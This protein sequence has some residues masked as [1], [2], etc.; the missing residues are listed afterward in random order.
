MHMARQ[1]ILNICIFT[2]LGLAIVL[3]SA[4]PVLAKSMSS[5][6]WTFSTGI[7][8][9]APSVKGE[10]AYGGDIDVDINEIVDNL[11]IAF[12]GLLTARK[13]KFSLLVDVIYM[14]LEDTSNY[15]LTSGPLGLVRLSITNME[16]QAWVVT[17]AAAYTVVDT[18][19]LQLDLLA[20]ARYL[21]IDTDVE[22][23]EQGPLETR[24]FS[25]SGSN[26]VWDGIVGAR[27]SVKINEKWHLPFHFDVGTG[28]TDMTWQ[29]FGG[30]A[31]KFSNVDLVAGYRHLE[32]DFDDND[33]G[34]DI[35]NDLYISGP[36]VGFR[37]NF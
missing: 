33:T 37:Y 4:Q 35:F 7:Y 15:N 20:G 6:N 26:H 8:L 5:D 19:R 10:T 13:G 14:D 23:V 29:A 34:G 1:K 25:P 27:G 18:D 22:L 32:W 16:L 31:Y 12:M 30:V 11:D 28:D 17:P 2:L 3:Q 36:V 24:T 9:W 21:Y